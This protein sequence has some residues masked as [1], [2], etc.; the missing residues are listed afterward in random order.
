MRIIYTIGIYLY[1][2]LAAVLGIFNSKAKLWTRG[3][4][5][6]LSKIKSEFKDDG[7]KTIWIHSAS[8]GEFEQGIP[9]IEKLKNEN[10]KAKILVTF[11]SPSGYE[12]RK[13][14]P[15][16]DHVYYLPSDTSKNAK[17]FLDI[18]KPDVCVFIKYEFW[19]NYLYQAS[20]RDIPVIFISAIFRENQIFFKKIGG[21]MLKHLKKANYFFVQ[22]KISKELL[23]RE[24]IDQVS[25]TGDTRFDRVLSIAQ[26][27]KLNP[28]VEAFKNGEKLFLAGS[29]WPQDENCILELHNKHPELK[30]VIAPH[31]IDEAHIKQIK[32]LFKDAVCFSE[33]NID[34][35][36]KSPILIVD[37]MGLLSSLYQYAEYALIGGGFGVGI[38]NTLEAATFGMPIFIGPNYHKF[39]EAKDLI[40]NGVAFVFEDAGQLITHFEDLYHNS[41]KHAK[42]VETSK[43]Y[44]QSKTGAT[45]MILEL[46]KEYLDS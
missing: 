4:K 40:E 13:D 20:K 15:L 22:N 29:S 11:Y 39:Q 35:I 9:L 6:L 45:Q 28:I 17:A 3:R 16:A 42:V 44:V 19:F 21:W 12:I 26:S 38:H 25:I 14:Y 23:Q 18:I 8:L 34:I 33:A 46:T 37:N 41:T 31:L 5:G 10:P 32:S 1:A 27:A 7:K 43:K 36:S 24:G 30:I 2:V